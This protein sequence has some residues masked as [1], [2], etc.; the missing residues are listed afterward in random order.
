M[1]A[2]RAKDAGELALI[3]RAAAATAP[4]Y[5][6]LR[7]RIAASPHAPRIRLLGFQADVR[8]LFEAMD[9][10]ALS[11]IREGLPNVV[12]EAM[13]MEVSVLAT[14]CGGL[15]AFGR[16]GEDMLLVEPA[17]VGALATGLE[18][19]ARDPGLRA[20]L[21]HT[22]RV[23]VQAEHGFARRMERFRSVYDRL[24]DGST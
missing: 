5:A 3:R 13:A 19:L 16:D 6:S 8:S 24:V 2:R 14:R 22:A 17:S 18:R 9:I 12:L 11:S 10:F 7:E 20:R 15:A 21:A 4:A 1:H 23:R